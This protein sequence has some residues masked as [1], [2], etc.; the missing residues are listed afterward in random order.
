[1]VP[2]TKYA[3][4]KRGNYRMRMYI[5]FIQYKN[6]TTCTFCG[7]FVLHDLD[8]T[9]PGSLKLVPMQNQLQVIISGM[10]TVSK[11]FVG[12]MEGTLICNNSLSLPFRGL[13]SYKSSHKPCNG[14]LKP[15][16]IDVTTTHPFINASKLH[17]VH[18]LLS[19]GKKQHGQNIPWPTLI[20]TVCGLKIR[21]A[22]ELIKY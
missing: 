18:L 6:R 4:M 19:V 3:Q 9:N 1:M 21:V 2:F 13:G 5:S 12:W 8:Q 11:Q 7:H 14:S 16:K 20:Y 17:C 10:P 15:R 22:Y